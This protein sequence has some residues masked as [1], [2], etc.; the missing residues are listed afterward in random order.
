[1]QEE[2]FLIASLVALGGGVG[3]I[4]GLIGIGGNSLMSPIMLWIFYKRLVYPVDS[5]IKTAFGTSLLVGMVT[6]LIGFLT[7]KNRIGW[8][9]EIV[10]P[11]TIPLVVGAIS[12]SYAAG[13]LSAGFLKTALRFALFLVSF[14]MIY[15]S[16]KEES[17]SY[18]FK[19][20]KPLLWLSG[21]IIGFFA[22]LV[23]MGG[24]VFTSIV[25]VNIFKYPIHKI[26]GI[27]TFVQIFGALSGAI[28]YLL[29]GYINWRVGLFALI[30][31]IPC[32]YLGAKTTHRLD[33]KWLKRI[34]A[35]A[36]F[37]MAVKIP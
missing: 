4:S 14:Y 23:G 33:P 19:F 27:T 6:A 5:A 34:F 17:H 16:I 35:V 31:S 26:V 2:I 32:A 3:F 30:G 18:A 1:M 29:N 21:F 10:I 24:A 11:L 37:I 12:G 36:L 8:Q 9:K 28:G 25:F 20:S 13:V 7:H 15:G 22:S